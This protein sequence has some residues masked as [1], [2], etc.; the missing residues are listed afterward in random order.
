MRIPNV[1]FVE[2]GPL[3]D[4]TPTLRMSREAFAESIAV[5]DLVGDVDG[6]ATLGDPIRSF[7]EP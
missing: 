6:S 5:V 4:D 2:A 3:D 7:D 1:A